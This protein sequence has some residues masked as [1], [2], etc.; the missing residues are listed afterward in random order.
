M[1][2]Q[3]RR[4]L[5]PLLCAAATAA[6]VASAQSATADHQ[7]GHT[8]GPGNCEA[9]DTR[10][11]CNP[12]DCPGA[13]TQNCDTAQ[14]D[15]TGGCNVHATVHNPHCA[16]GG[17][18]TPPPDGDDDDDDD[19]GGDVVT[20]GDDG[21]NAVNPGAEPTT[22]G[23]PVTSEVGGV[24]GTPRVDSGNSGVLT[25]GVVSAA[26]MLLLAALVGLTAAGGVMASRR[27][28]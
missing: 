1:R 20:P 9:G 6:L 12:N 5:L 8:T 10:P 7:P 25:A 22:Q 28:R 17:Q 2:A 13:Q 19:T 18:V 23:Q 15:P 4:W 21:D 16:E 27:V 26:E 3:T 14:T 11:V 24:R